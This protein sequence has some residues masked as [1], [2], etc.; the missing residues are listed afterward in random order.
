MAETIPIRTALES[1]SLSFHE[2]RAWS[3]ATTGTRLACAARRAARQNCMAHGP[4]ET[5]SCAR[6]IRCPDPLQFAICAAF[7]LRIASVYTG[8]ARRGIELA[9]SAATGRVSKKTGEPRSED[10]VVRA[11]IGELSIAFDGLTLELRALTGDLDTLVDHGAGWFP[12][13]SGMKHR[14]VTT[15]QR[16]VDDAAVSAGGGA[17]RNAHELARLVRDVRAGT[18]HPSSPDSARQAAAAAWLGAQG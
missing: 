16:I 8:I 14:A 5:V 17:F 6:S 15:A 12:L 10:P 9:A 1:C 11:R 7:E 4:R 13:L 2:T 3:H 18:F